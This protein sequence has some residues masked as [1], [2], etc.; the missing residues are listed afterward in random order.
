MSALDRDN[1]PFKRQKLEPTVLKPLPTDILLLSLPQL[2][3]HPPTHRNHARA[4]FLSSF[5][6][7]K[8]LSLPNLEPNLE[9]QAWTE[10]AETGLKIG[11]DT[12]G[13]EDEVE[14]AITKALIIA[15]KHP[16]LRYYKPQITRLSARLAIHQGNQKLAQNTLKKVL[17]N[18]IVP[19][20]PLHVQYAAHLAYISS[21]SNASDGDEL[22]PYSP[23]TSSLKSLGAIRDL[24]DLAKLNNHREV[25]LF[26][27][28]LE[29]RDLAHNGIWNRVGE[30]LNNAEKDLNL[31]FE[32]V[33]ESKGPLNASPAVPGKTKI[34]KVLIIHVLVIGILFYTYIG[35][36][37]DTQC[38]IKKLHEMLDGG[39]LQAFGVSGIVDIDLPDLPPLRVQVTH[40]RVIFAL[41]FLVSSVSKRDPVG[42]KPKRKVFASEGVL[43]VDKELK[44]DAP[45][46]IWSSVADANEFYRRMSKMKADM[47]CEIIGVCISRSEFDEAE[48]NLSQLIADTRT[49]GLF[50]IYS[51][52]I[53]LHQAHLAHGLGRTE[54]ALKCYQVA[55]YLSRKRPSNEPASDEDDSCED[56]WVNVSA[57]AGELWLLIG[58]ASEVIDAAQREYEMEALR[59]AGAGVVKECEGLGGTLKAIGAVLAASLSK[60]FLVTKTHLR[61][62]LN[63]STAAQDNHLR[64]LVL[65]LVAAQYV[66][67]STEHAESMLGTAEQ[68]AAGLGAQPKAVK[69]ADV[70]KCPTP[71]SAAGATA[72]GDGIGNAHLRLWIGER[73]LELKK[74]AADEKGAL[75]QA[76]VNE[77][78]KDAVARVQK[79]KFNDV[80]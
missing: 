69:T 72:G 22:S 1:R 21:H 6:L 3:A 14:K 33:E 39:A 40:P 37:K 2:L 59:K 61:T 29:L 16:S 63:L 47:I 42:R 20:D 8:Y 12:V 76:V 41:G 58:A 24:H 31:L 73:S 19:S 52:R 51:A 18:F 7:R 23:S 4:N 27:M 70:K 45:L 15:H 64:A 32:P 65:S 74:R 26:A 50:S 68:L 5:A 55:A 66:H 49:H 46:P 11:L 56:Y 78:F 54:K 43:V 71:K 67:T 79:R 35:S 9:C 17:T 57:R 53:T 38:R 48:H 80:D 44:T 77:K 30:S 34:E 25:V 36:S 28:V 13:V 60:E 75:K 10:L 62:A